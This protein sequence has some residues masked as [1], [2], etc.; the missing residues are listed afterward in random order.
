M[1]ISMRDVYLRLC[2]C[3]KTNDWS[4]LP[5]FLM[6]KYFHLNKNID[7]KLVGKIAKLL[8]NSLN[9]ELSR[10][11]EIL[12]LKCLTNCCLENFKYKSYNLIEDTKI[13][14]YHTEIYDLLSDDLHLEKIDK[15]Y[16][17]ETHFPY[18][19]I[20][21]WT[22]D[23]IFQLIAKEDKKFTNEELDI[24]TQCMQFLSNF[25]SSACK[26]KYS[27][28]LNEAPIYLDS[29]ELKNV[30][31]FLIGHEHMP[32]AKAACYFI[33]NT[34]M[35]KEE[36]YISDIKKNEL[37]KN[38]I[39]ATKLE[40]NVAQYMLNYFIENGKFLENIYDNLL[41]DDR[42][43]ILEIIN[44]NLLNEIYKNISIDMTKLIAGK[45]KRKSDLILKTVDTYLD[46]MQPM[47]VMILLNILGILSSKTNSNYSIFLREDKSLLINALYLLKSIHMVG[48]ESNNF[49][50]PLQKL[51]EIAITN[52]QGTSDLKNENSDKSENQN[53]QTHPAYGFKAGLVRLIGNLVFENENNQN[54]VR[55]EEGIPLLLDCC[56]IDARN[57]LIIQWIILAIKNLCNKNIANQ[58][59][60]QECTKIGVVDSAALKEMGLTLND[61]G[62]GKAIGIMPML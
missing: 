24:L 49:F 11:T 29:E 60:I 62:D 23:R 58:N 15:T 25:V 55:E 7:I 54:L 38:L 26:N 18:D 43:F 30:I 12:L 21:K 59:L 50:T 6:P 4:T 47:E 13:S 31:L 9:F 41:I 17:F 16:P 14:K 45:F 51:S 8:I 48:R 40:I 2:L 32:L 28:D 52:N 10:K 57:P 35:Y 34:V 20:I 36:N 39:N 27:P 22:V 56:N 3:E 46:G 33:Y 42:L 53:F 1:S 44:E 19:G 61:E 37:M 5:E